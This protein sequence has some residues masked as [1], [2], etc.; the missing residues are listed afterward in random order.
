MGDQS[1]WGASQGQT[2]P[3]GPELQGTG[4]ASHGHRACC[5]HLVVCGYSQGSLPSFQGQE[6]TGRQDGD[7]QKGKACACCGALAQ[8]LFSE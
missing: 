6:K 7:G 3:A 8:P 4:A 1:V 5:P 2:H